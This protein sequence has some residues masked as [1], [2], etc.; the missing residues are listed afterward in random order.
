MRFLATKK[1]IQCNFLLNLKFY[2]CTLTQFHSFY[3]LILSYREIKTKYLDTLQYTIGGS[4]L[5]TMKTISVI[6][7]LLKL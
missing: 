4:G 3:L 5:N 7:T 2:R 6:K 1:T